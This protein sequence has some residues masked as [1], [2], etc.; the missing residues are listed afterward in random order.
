MYFL[1]SSH[2][3]VCTAVKLATAIR[4]GLTRSPYSNAPHSALQ[5][6]FSFLLQRPAQ[7]HRLRKLLHFF[8]FLFPGGVLQPF[9]VVL[10]PDISEEYR[11]VILKNIP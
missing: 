7:D 2:P 9:S 8:H 11:K 3:P 6:C 4:C 5:R 10:N 1:R